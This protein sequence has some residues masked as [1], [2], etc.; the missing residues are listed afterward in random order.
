V[1]STDTSD[2]SDFILPGFDFSAFPPGS[3]V[4][5][6]GCG[7]GDQLRMLEQAGLGAIGVEPR[8]DMVDA[9]VAEG[10]D[11]RRGVAEQLPLADG[12]CDG[13]ICKVVVPYTDERK[14]ISEWARVLRPG[15]PALVAYHGAGYYVRYVVDGPGL[16]PRIYGLRSLVN[17]W[18]YAA[19]ER[20][21]PGFV[22]DTLYQSTKRLAEYY[23][24]FGLVLERAWPSPLYRGKPVFIYH[25][26]RRLATTAR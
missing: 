21:L 3:Q 25:E 5:D 12:S 4:L 20:R 9:L 19:T 6:V 26:L 1:T 17:T 7:S 10:F 22:G 8:Q 14:A 13:L 23:R 16:M 24:E 18:W 2:W 15:A 11:V